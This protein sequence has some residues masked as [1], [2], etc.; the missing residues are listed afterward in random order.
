MYDSP[1]YGLYNVIYPIVVFVY[2]SYL[3]I[4]S[5]VINGGGSV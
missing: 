4:T 5:V 2:L 3:N 1:E